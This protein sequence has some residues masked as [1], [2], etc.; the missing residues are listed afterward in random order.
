MDWGGVGGLGRGG[1][2]GE[3]WVDWGGVGGLGRGRV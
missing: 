1:W 2:I 3:G